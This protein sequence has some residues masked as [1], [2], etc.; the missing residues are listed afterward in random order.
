MMTIN[1]F[2]KAILKC[3][4]IYEAL[5]LFYE[6]LDGGAIA[7]VTT[8]VEWCGTIDG[9]TAYFCVFPKDAFVEAFYEEE[10][11]AQDLAYWLE[12][13]EWSTLMKYCLSD[14]Y[15]IDI[16]DDEDKLVL[17]HRDFGF[18]DEKKMEVM[19]R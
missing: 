2:K 3:E 12:D 5:E 6:A 10:T 14:F 1:E 7:E 11:F 17:S 9:Y 13:G 16:F 19:S 18:T 4:D 15:F 8:A